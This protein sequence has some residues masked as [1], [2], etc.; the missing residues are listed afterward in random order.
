M[1]VLPKKNYSEVN[2]PSPI[3]PLMLPEVG[4]IFFSAHMEILRLSAI[5]EFA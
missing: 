1:E 2:L 4:F 3:I 5:G